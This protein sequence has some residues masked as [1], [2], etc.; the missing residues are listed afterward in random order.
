MAQRVARGIALGLLE[1][2]R[3]GQLTIV[4]GERRLVL[5][6]GSPQ[7]TVHVR[8]PSLWPRL[9][10]GSRG[11]AEAY[12]H[13]LWE[14]PDLTAVV[15]VAARNASSLDEW[16]RRVAPARIPLQ[17]ARGIRAR[18]THARSRRGIAA[19]YDL[20]NELFA[21][22]LDE[23]MMYSSAYFPRQGMTLEQASRAKLDLVC[24][25]LDLRA[26]DHVLEIGTGWGGFAVHAAR[27][28]DCRVTTTTISREQYEHARR[29]VQAA[30]VAD[31][32]TVLCEDYRDLRGHYEK[33]VCIEMIEA[34]GYRDFDTFFARCSNL[35]AAHGRMLLQA[36]TIN[37]R[38]YEVEKAS[39]SF[40]RTHI[41]PGGCLP[42][43]AVIA[44]CVAQHTDMRTVGLKDLT[45]HYAET[46]RRWRTNFE[47]ATVR[48]EDLGYDERFRR[49]WRMYLAYCEAGFAE[50]R[51][52]VTQ[53]TLAKPGW[54]QHA[55][56]TSAYEAPRALAS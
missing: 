9:L 54:H 25:T 26:G 1:R 21:L 56:P 32:V 34:V 38:A 12:M 46:L 35:L 28:R 16:R 7:A 19:H 53:M 6:H 40:I 13:G 11:M 47:A 17:A 37:D 14:S 24:G 49:L 29:W 36:I 4:E 52:G 43:L 2:L 23:T 42:S 44:R 50:R 18:N 45:P 5:G 10:H 33:L 22:M 20:G 51:I 41:F 30:G 55:G 39:R 3:S 15:R 31:R 48:L 27:T 8:S